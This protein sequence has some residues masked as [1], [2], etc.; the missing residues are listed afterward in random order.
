MDIVIK[1]YHKI[2]SDDFMHP[3][4]TF[5]D[6]E[7]L[8]FGNLDPKGDSVVST[9]VR[10]GRSIDGFPFSTIISKEDRLLLEKKLSVV[11]KELTGEFAGTYHSL[12]GLDEDTKDKL[13]QDHF[14]FGDSNKIFQDAGGYRDW[15]VG[16]GIFYNKDKTFL[17]W[18]GEEDHLRV[19]SMQ[20]G[21]DLAATYARL[22]RGLK[23]IES[24]VQFCH[25]DKYGY[26]NCC[27]SNLGTSMR[28]S[29]HARVP[30][31]S[32]DKTKL[33]DICKQ[34]GL[35]ARGAYGEHT[36]SVGGVY[37]L[38]NERRLGLTELEA[39]IEMAE[40]VKKILELEATL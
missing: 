8:P 30:K 27:P 37:D 20:E 38:S 31:L 6:I 9:R 19:I 5:G 34:H 14:L 32:A 24:R 18:I 22:I 7:N 35:E 36:E 33:D 1:T 29:V 21:G 25:S 23:A 12:T 15:P 39:A 10:V 13:V 40:G 16:R 2:P 11:L 28:A 26:L 3:P 17:C 4:P